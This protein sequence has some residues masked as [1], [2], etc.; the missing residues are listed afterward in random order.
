M[1]TPTVRVLLVDD[2]AIVGESLRRMLEG[3]RD[4]VLEHCTDPV[5]AIVAA[6]RFQPTVVLLDLVMPVVDGLTVLRFLRAHPATRDV[7]VVVLSTKEDASVKAEAFALGANDYLVKLPDA[8]EVEARIRYHSAGFTV[9]LQRDAA[10]RELEANLQVQARLREELAVRNDFIQQTFGRFLSDDVVADLLHDPKGLALGGEKRTVTVMMTDLRG[11]TLLCEQLPAEQVVQL[12]NLYLGAMAPLILAHGGII[13]EFLGD[14][15]LAIFGA[16]V[17]REDD[18]RRALRCALDMQCAMPDVNARLEALGLPAVEMGIAL[19]TGSVVVGNIGS[20]RRMKYGVVGSH[21]NLASRIESHTVGG[22]VLAS[23]ATIDEVGAGSVVV[24]NQFTI[25]A[26]G[27][28]H[29]VEVYDVRGLR[30][31]DAVTLPEVD[32]A[33]REIEPIQLELWAVE[34]KSVV[35]EPFAGELVAL[36]HRTLVVRSSYRGELRSS[37]KLQLAGVPEL[38]VKITRATPGDPTFEA[39][40]GVMPA[41]L[42]ERWEALRGPG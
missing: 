11:F 32:E 5:K 40:V 26:K 39:R 33:V 38:Y 2:Q 35:G 31:S 41:V 18:A 22:Q 10:H 37:V 29:P 16:P 9:R 19:S 27:F 21:V 15:I 4:V 6:A 25:V 8:I 7:P 36:G 34:G 28:R 23:E 24:A 30:G 13:D 42:R 1:S 3:Q 20:D 17:S 12:L 14:A